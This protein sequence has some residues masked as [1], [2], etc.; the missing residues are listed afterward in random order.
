MEWGKERGLKA[1]NFPAPRADYP[2]Y[3]DPVY[4][5]FFAAAAA[6]ELP[7]IT[8]AGSGAL[9]A[10]PRD[11]PGTYMLVSFEVMGLSRRALPQM[12]FGGVFDRHPTLHLSF[13]EQR[14]TWVGETLRD[15]DSCYLDP[16]R[17]Y[18][19]K[20]LK[21]PSD[22]WRENCSIGASFM[23]PFE[24]ARRDEVGTHN[25]M[26][27]SDYPHAEGTWP[28]TRLAMRNTFADVP[29]EDVRLILGENALRVFDAD[30]NELRHIAGQIGPT[31]D[32][33][34]QPLAPEEFPTHR[35]LSFRE[36]GIFA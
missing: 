4:E 17:D 12:I 18:A 16:N 30:V 33:L 15:L 21:R 6:L 29:E 23:A 36:L 25:I 3:N 8:H 14:V 20:T 9:T 7:L 2:A 26:W 27:G 5:P 19:D 28:R 10:G 32:D 31:P 11:L 34:A 22:Y 1:V 35:G 24:A 13:T